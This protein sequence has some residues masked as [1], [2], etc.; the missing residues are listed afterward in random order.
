MKTNRLERAVAD[1]GDEEGSIRALVLSC[2]KREICTPSRIAQRL[3]ITTRQ[4]SQALDTLRFQDRVEI[5]QWG[6]WRMKEAVPLLA[7]VWK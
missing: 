7:Q 2:V 5:S 3:G 1:T 6:R 4:V